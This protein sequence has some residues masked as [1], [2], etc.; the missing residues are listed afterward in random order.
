MRE[1]F[2]HERDP[3]GGM[4]VDAAREDAAVQ[5]D[6][7]CDAIQFE[8]TMLDDREL[9]RALLGGRT[10]REQL[11]ERREN[12]GDA[13]THD[14]FR[15]NRIDEPRGTDRTQR[16]DEDALEPSHEQRDRRLGVRSLQQR[17]NERDARRPVGV[18]ALAQPQTEK[19]RGEDGTRRRHAVRKCGVLQERG[20][21]R[22]GQRTAKAQQSLICGVAASARAA[23]DDERRQDAPSPMLR[24]DEEAGRERRDE[25]NAHLQRHLRA[26]V[27]LAVLRS[28][29]L[30]A[31]RRVTGGLLLRETSAR[32]QELHD[33]NPRNGNQPR[34]NDECE[35][36]HRAARRIRA[37]RRDQNHD[38][39]KRDE[40]TDFRGARAELT[41]PN[42]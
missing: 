15:S 1:Q 17:Q 16:A 41:Q 31:R 19:Q 10:A 21:D 26:R 32:R 5:F 11:L 27:E 37:N 36:H 34:A 38:E 33:R 2:A 28:A 39:R 40:A 22:P 24:K 23:A 13:A 12:V 9:P 8:R 25:R 18:V 30:A 20:A 35:V 4:L 42:R 14:R 3:R 6:W 29:R 7:R